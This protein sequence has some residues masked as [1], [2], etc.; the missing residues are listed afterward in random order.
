MH[1]SLENQYIC[2]SK[3]NGKKDVIKK[4][5]QNSYNGQL[6]LDCTRIIETRVDHDQIQ[7]WH[8]SLMSMQVRNHIQSVNRLLCAIPQ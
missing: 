5:K 2:W 6:P 8:N 3:S 1:G 7:G 4:K